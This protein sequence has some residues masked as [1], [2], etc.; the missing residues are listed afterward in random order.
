M[1]MYISIIDL[2]KHAYL[3]ETGENDALVQG[4]AGNRGERA[5]SRAS[6]RGHRGRLGDSSCRQPVTLQLNNPLVKLQILLL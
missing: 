3:G 6:N 5:V 4:N 1:Q 2:L